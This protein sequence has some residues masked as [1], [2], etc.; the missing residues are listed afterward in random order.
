[1]EEPVELDVRDVQ[2]PGKLT[3]ERCLAAPLLPL[4][5]YRVT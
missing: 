2:P 5:Q 3:R 4:T 1:V